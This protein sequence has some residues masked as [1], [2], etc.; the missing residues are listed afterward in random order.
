[1]ADLALVGKVAVERGLAHPRCAAD[2]VHAGRI[3]PLRCKELLR[4]SEKLLAV[5]ARVAA[6]AAL[7]DSFNL[8][9][10]R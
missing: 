7:G 8:V 1:M 2:L 5:L 10:H 4:H 9:I 3:D 6:L